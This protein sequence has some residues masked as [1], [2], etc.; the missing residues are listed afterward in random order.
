MF[1]YGSR[2]GVW[3]VLRLFEKYALPLTLNACALA[4]ERNVEL[5]A[6]I[7]EKSYDICC[8]GWRWVDHFRLTEDEE[9]RHIAKAIESLQRVTGHRPVGWCCRT[10]PSVNTR[11]LLVEA[12]GF[13]YDSDVYNDELPYWVDVGGTDQLTLPEYPQR[14]QRQRSLRRVP[15][16]RAPTTRG[17]TATLST[18]SIAKAPSSQR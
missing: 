13:L 1:E 16:P 18:G 6:A 7:R 5:A 14:Y 8:H 15:S 3:R 9:R 11:R 17:G 2:I 4:V 12:G 10:G